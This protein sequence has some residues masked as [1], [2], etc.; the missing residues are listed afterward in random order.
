MSAENLVLNEATIKTTRQPIGKL[1]SR[2]SDRLPVWRG[3]PLWKRLALWRRM[4]L[5][6]RVGAWRSLPIRANA[7]WRALKWRSARFPSAICKSDR[8][9]LVLTKIRTNPTLKKRSPFV[10]ITFLYALTYA[11]ST[12]LTFTA[13]LFGFS[14]FELSSAKETGGANRIERYLGGRRVSLNFRM[15]PIY[16]HIHHWVYLCLLMLTVC[17]FGGRCSYSDMI[18]GACLGGAFQGMKYSDCF[19]VIWIDRQRWHFK[20]LLFKKAFP[21]ASI[22]ASIGSCPA[23]ESCPADHPHH[24]NH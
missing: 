1:L 16:V 13:S 17:K 15:G 12:M 6:K 3:L 14:F 22:K 21:R 11:H 24:Y 4:A 18:N 2:L 19:S 10:L 7:N 23:N 5:W 8:F 9:C 20:N